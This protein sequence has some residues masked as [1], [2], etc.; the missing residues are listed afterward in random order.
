M[1]LWVVLTTF[2]AMIA[3]FYLPMRADTADKQDVGVARA[4]LVQMVAKH[5]AVMQYMMENTHPYYCAPGHNCND[6]DTK[7]IVGYNAGYVMP[8]SL[9]A[10]MPKGFYENANYVSYI[11]CM[12]KFKNG[13]GYED[14]GEGATC[15]RNDDPP[16]YT[17][18]R[19]VITYGAI[20]EHW[21]A[22]TKEG[23]RTLLRPSPDM[24]AAMREQ[25]SKNEIAGY[26][27]YDASGNIVAVNYEKTPIEIPA[28]MIDETG[29]KGLTTCL[30]ENGTCLVYVSWR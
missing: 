11:Y 7:R 16:T 19:A 3:A 24:I 9:A 23:D 22:Y 27:Y 15:N 13:S 25:F 12:K 14:K 2:L 10:Y 26:A 4:Q 20:P 18:M 17:T 8:G 29:A 21:Q 28:P 30:N 5:K 1:Y 6:L